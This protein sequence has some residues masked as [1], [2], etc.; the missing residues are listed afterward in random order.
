MFSNIGKLLNFN[1]F[2]AAVSQIRIYWYIYILYNTCT[3]YPNTKKL[4]FSAVFRIIII[5]RTILFR[6]V[7]SILRPEIWRDRPLNISQAQSSSKRKNDIR[8]QLTVF[9]C[10]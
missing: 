6:V 9:E 5:F 1:R 10:L 2:F 7:F 8:A 3:A 4:P